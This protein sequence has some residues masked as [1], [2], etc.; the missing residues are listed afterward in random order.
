MKN[1]YILGGGTFFHVRPHLALSAPAFGTVAHEIRRA[2]SEWLL[3]D[4]PIHLRL[5]RMAGGPA[6]LETNADVA[7]LLDTIIADP[8]AGIVFMSAALCDF[9]GSVLEETEDSEGRPMS[10]NTTASGKDQ[11]RLKTS[12]GDQHMILRPSD[13]LLGRIRKDRKDIFLVGFK[14][15]SGATPQ[16]QYE[17][18]LSLLKK[19]SCNLVFANDVHTRLNMVVAPELARYY[20]TN[21]RLAAVQ[22]L[23]EMAVKRSRLHF[24]RTTIEEGKLI[25]WDSASVPQSLRK[26]VD[27]CIERGAYKPFNNV[28]VGH[29][30]WRDPSL[31]DVL[32]SSR[33]KQNYNLPG[34]RDLVH[35]QFTDDK[36]IAWGAKPSAGT[37]SQWAVLKTF[38]QFDCIVHFHCPAREGSSVPVRPQHDFEC[39]SHECGENTKLGMQLYSNGLIGAVML[40][41]HGPN[42]IFNRSIDPYI[43][44]AFIE[45][46]FD[47][48]K[49]SDEA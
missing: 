15:T 23:V 47:L 12:E 43:V 28:T 45:E 26:V 21:D 9:E 42:V 16:D 32:Y 49:R 3:H 7:K 48:T 41:K 40:D 17:A 36:M 25:P 33:R 4:E 2:L 10:P 31:R 46:N 1:H 5:T 35:V 34:G 39:G 29:F 37:R 6:D 38:S 27:H 44:I 14:T 13:K 8:H 11:P 30:A 24:T 18:G 19:N 20:E 22:G